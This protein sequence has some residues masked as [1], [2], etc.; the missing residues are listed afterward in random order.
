MRK[1]ALLAC[2]FCSSIINGSNSSVPVYLYAHGLANTATQAFNYKGV[3]FDGPVVTFDFPDATRNFWRVN[4]VNCALGQ[5][6]D[7]DHMHQIILDRSRKAPRSTFVGIGVSRGAGAWLNYMGIYQT[8]QVKALVLESPFDSIASTVS[9]I[10]HA[11]MPLIFMQ[12]DEKGLHPRDV[13]AQIPKELPILITCVKDDHRVPYT[14]TVEVYRLLKESGHPHVHMLVFESGN[15]GTF[16]LESH[17]AEYRNVA[18]AFY[19]KYG[20]P[21]N[22][23]AAKRGQRLFA[24]TQPDP[25][26]LLN[27]RSHDKHTADQTAR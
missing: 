2:I 21:Y 5:R 25:Q 12:Y 15:H 1:I 11:F 17:R 18:H 27:E 14:S 23:K 9:P 26:E 10:A 20:L 24:T 13:I 3:L 19:K 4:I 6:Q 16:V 22:K 8:P 7:I